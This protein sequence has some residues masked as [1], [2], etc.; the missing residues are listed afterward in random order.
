MCVVP[1]F[2]LTKN[3]YDSSAERAFVE[4]TQIGRSSPRAE[5]AL[6]RAKTAVGRRKMHRPILKLRRRTLMKLYQSITVCVALMAG[7]AADGCFAQS[8]IKQ[9][10]SVAD[11]NAPQVSAVAVPTVT[12]ATPVSLGKT[13]AQV[14][15]EL[16][17][18]QNSDQAAQ[19]R[20]LY[21]GSK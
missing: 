4:C 15:R 16:D 21:R 10:E 1:A 6:A 13:R 18:F 11:G 20:Q 17:D 2:R 14:I 3:E 12:P 5:A 8:A 19:M 9:E 7:V